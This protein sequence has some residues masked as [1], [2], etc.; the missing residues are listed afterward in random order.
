MRQVLSL[1]EPSLSAQFS[2]RPRL[3][4]LQL[5]RSQEA[6][7][8]FRVLSKAQGVATQLN[9]SNLIYAQ[10][11]SLILSKSSIG[12]FPSCVAF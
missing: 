8:Q 3:P 10:R 9:C 12:D 4:F 5:T 7:R 1:P 2:P 11:C 6:E